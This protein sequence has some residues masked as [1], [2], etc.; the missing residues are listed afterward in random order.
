M[1]W[2]VD[3]RPISPTA[4]LIQGWRGPCLCLSSSGYSHASSGTFASCDGDSFSSPSFSS[5]RPGHPSC[6]ACE[7]TAVR[8]RSP[9]RT[10]KLFIT[11]GHQLDENSKHSGQPPAPG[12]LRAAEFVGVAPMFSICAS[13][14]AWI[15]PLSRYPRDSRPPRSRLT[16][17]CLRKRF[18]AH[19]RAGRRDAA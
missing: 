10:K 13:S 6:P 14:R 11:A 1:S 19:A 17:A 7:A 3:R 12:M 9:R 8:E 2:L 15:S 4:I 16:R 18:R 5:Y